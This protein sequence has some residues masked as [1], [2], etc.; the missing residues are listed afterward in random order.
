[1]LIDR[2]SCHRTDFAEQRPVGTAA[3]AAIAATAA[4][5]AITGAPAAVI[6]ENH[7]FT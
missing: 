4:T 2:N 7:K 5:A 6:G 1:M 3:I